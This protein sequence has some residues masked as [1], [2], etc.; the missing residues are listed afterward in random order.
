MYKLNV[1]D[2][3]SAAH[4]LLGYDGACQNLHG[5][6]YK[7][8]ISINCRELDEIGLALDYKVIKT[9]LAGVLD[10]LDHAYLN[11]V[12]AL[13]GINPTSENLA[14]YIFEQMSRAISK[15]GASV[16]EV[17]IYESEKSSVIYTRD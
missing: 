4:R 9:A 8:R 15:P 14:R 17:E 16:N 5:H 13:A 6:N 7:I 3:F 12:P 2:S 11:D 10:E 1:T